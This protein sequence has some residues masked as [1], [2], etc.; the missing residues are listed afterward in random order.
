M[1]DVTVC[2]RVCCAYLVHRAVCLS[3]CH[4]STRCFV[5]G[6]G[7]VPQPLHMGYHDKQVHPSRTYSTLDRLWYHRVLVRTTERKQQTVM[8][9]LLQV[10]RESDLPFPSLL[11]S[12]YYTVSVRMVLE[13]SANELCSCESRSTFISIMRERC[14][15]VAINLDMSKR[16][17]TI[18]TLTIEH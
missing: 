16:Y 15:L 13:Y 3:A 10:F 8:S 12:S 11:Q 4:S 17:Y 7:V 14:C 5:I 9:Q 2:Q 1:H 6:F 18:T